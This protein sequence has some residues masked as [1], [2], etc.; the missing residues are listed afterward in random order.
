MEQKKTISIAKKL[1]REYIFPSYPRFRSISK[2]KVATHATYLILHALP[3]GGLLHSRV[4][5]E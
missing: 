2:V 4:S 1:P 5:N 3:L